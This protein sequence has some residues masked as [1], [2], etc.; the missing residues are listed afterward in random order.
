MHALA[1]SPSAPV[2]TPMPVVVDHHPGFACSQC[3]NR[4]REMRACRRCGF[5]HLMDLDRSSVRD[6]LR[7]KHERRLDVWRDRRR[8]A[9]V[10]AAMAMVMLC[11]FIP[12]FWTFRHQHFA[13][14]LLADQLGAMVLLCL[15][16]MSLLDRVPISTH[17]PWLDSLPPSTRY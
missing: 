4:E 16:F 7:E 8:M 13:L 2:P 5:A 11:W 12:G 10:L 15:G 6:L 3:G 17:Y 14:P 9:S 1:T